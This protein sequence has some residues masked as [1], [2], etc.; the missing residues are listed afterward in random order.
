MAK[1]RHG[2]EH[3]NVKYSTMTLKGRYNTRKRQ[4]TWFTFENKEAR[5][6]LPVEDVKIKSETIAIRT[7]KT[8]KMVGR[9]AH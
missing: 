3:V 8:V 9:L 4:K 6:F 7:Y 1:G 5:V 2:R